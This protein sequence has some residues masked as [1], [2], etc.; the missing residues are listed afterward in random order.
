MQEVLDFLMENKIFYVATI[1]GD[2][3][4]IRP[5]GFVMEFEGIVK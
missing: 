3:P 4:K 1:D 5:F 2:K